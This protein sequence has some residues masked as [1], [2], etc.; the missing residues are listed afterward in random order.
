MRHY[1]RKLFDTQ[2]DESLRKLVST[3]AVIAISWN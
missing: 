3:S 2:G 1:A